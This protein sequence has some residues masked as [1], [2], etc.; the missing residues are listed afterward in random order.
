MA[1]KGHKPRPFS[2][3]EQFQ[4]NFDGIPNFGFKPK[5]AKELDS[6]RKSP[7]TKDELEQKSPSR[8]DTI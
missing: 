2:D 6:K 5:W 4:E 8:K 1:G 7:Y 3:Y